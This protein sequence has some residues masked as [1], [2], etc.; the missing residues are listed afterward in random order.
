M[1]QD[2]KE[3]MLSDFHEVLE[4]AFDDSNEFVDW[5]IKNDPGLA[6]EVV[7]LDQEDAVEFDGT[8]STGSIFKELMAEG[9]KFLREHMETVKGHFWE[10][11]MKFIKRSMPMIEEIKEMLKDHSMNVLEAVKAAVTKTL[12]DIMKPDKKK[13]EV[14]TDEEIEGEFKDQLA[15]KVRQKAKELHVSFT[16]F[17][18]KAWKAAKKHFGDAKD[19]IVNH[20][21]DLKDAVGETVVDILDN[22]NPDADEFALEDNDMMEFAGEPTSTWGIFREIIREGKVI[23]RQHMEDIKGHFFEY[24]K[25]F[26]AKIM[27][28]LSELKNKL[29]QK[30]GHIL[31]D[32][33]K[34]VKDAMNDILKPIEEKK[35]E[36]ELEE[37]IK[38]QFSD[39]VARRLRNHAKDITGHFTTIYQ[40]IMRS[41]KNAVKQIKEKMKVHH[42]D[43]ADAVKETV[44]KVLVDAGVDAA[45]ND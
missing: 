15:R 25:K 17:F 41:A 8:P 31:E 36:E 38:G 14:V 27:P 2:L 33:A 7:R 5:L 30:K 20:H 35:K 12:D 40:R 42:E 32:I 44:T 24:L 19:K 9:R 29:L 37:E 16:S 4:K 13:P 1:V 39:Q 34:V 45:K 6:E 3:G 21:K 22:L 10:Y 26:I 28:H 23:L 11:L 18:N 43:I